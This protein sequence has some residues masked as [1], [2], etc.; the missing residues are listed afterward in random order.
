MQEIG[1]RLSPNPQTGD[2]TLLC[3]GLSDSQHISLFVMLLKC[4][5][6]APVV[7]SGTM[8][9]SQARLNCRVA[10]FLHMLML[11]LATCDSDVR[12]HP[13]PRAFLPFQLLYRLGISKTWHGTNNLVSYAFWS[14]FIMLPW[15]VL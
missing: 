11:M 3:S 1:C 2:S 12:S 13:I 10:Q 14:H 5:T 6:L 15:T 9:T 8:W 4:M 7:Q